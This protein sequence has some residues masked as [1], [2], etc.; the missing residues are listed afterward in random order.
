MG[1]EEPT[2]A[3]N[4]AGFRAV[5]TAAG[6]L[7]MTV[8]NVRAGASGVLRP[9]SQCLIASRLKPNVSE[10]LACVMPSRLRIAEAGKEATLGI[11]GEG[12]FFGEGGLGGQFT[13]TSSA[14]TL[15]DCV[16]LHVEKQAMTHAMSTEPKLSAMFNEAPGEAEH[17]IPGRPG[18]STFQ[19]QRKAT[20]TS[21]SVDGAL[22]QRGRVRNV[23]PETK[24]G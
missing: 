18:R 15:T 1:L 8:S 6:F 4:A 17:S 13:R 23:H 5:S 2:A 9:P 19:L 12:D 24:P 10:N 14:I 20:G 22:G 7:S 21:S 16:L 11:L 3:A